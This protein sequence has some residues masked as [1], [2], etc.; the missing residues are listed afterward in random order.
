MMKAPSTALLRT[1]LRPTT[2]ECCQVRHSSKWMPRESFAKT[3]SLDKLHRRQKANNRI[4]RMLPVSSPRRLMYSHLLGQNS[5]KRAQA[6]L[7]PSFATPSETS[8]SSESQLSE[9]SSPSTLSSLSTPPSSNLVPSTLPYFVHRTKTRNF[10]VYE[11]HK[12][13]GSKHIT[14]IRKCAGD[15]D[16]LQQHLTAALNL[17]PS[18]VDPRG[19]KKYNVV[20]NRLTNQI[21]VRGWRSAEIKKWCEVVGF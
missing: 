5:E 8:R 3:T 20:V 18:F 17:Q 6:V 2:T 16:A 7:P 9:A 1:F 14:T 21:V 10:P 15:L 13:G 11:S 4:E 19:N 12:A